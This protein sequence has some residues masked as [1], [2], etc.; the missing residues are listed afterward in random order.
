MHAAP[1]EGEPRPGAVPALPLRRRTEL[2]NA[3]RARHSV[4]VVVIVIAA[5]GGGKVQV[6][7]VLVSPL[8]PPHFTAVFIIS[9]A[10]DGK[11]ETSC[12]PEKLKKG[13]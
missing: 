4:F 13:G 3:A 12:V 2:P 11:D 1:P 10:G 8:L 5:G 7:G 9:K 6:C